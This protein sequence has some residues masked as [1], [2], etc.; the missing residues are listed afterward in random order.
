MHARRYAIVF[1]SDEALAGRG[2]R[3][4]ALYDSLA[5]RG[6][7]YQ[8]RHG[9][10]RPGWFEKSSSE[11]L[12]SLESLLPKPYDFYGAYSEE[13]SGWRLGEGVPATPKHEAHK[14]NELIEGELT[15]GW[16]AS[17]DAVAEE[18]RAA[19]EGVA[20]FDTSYFGKLLLDG[21]KADAAMQWMCAADL[22]NK[23]EGSVTYTPLC[24]ANG[25]V[26]ADLT[27]TKLGENKWYL[28]TGGATQ[29]HD[30]RWMLE[31]M[32]AGGFGGSGGGHGDGDRGVKL[33]N[34]SDDITL[35]SVQGPKSHE[36]LRPLV[37]DGGIDDLDA[38]GFSTARTVMFAGVPGVRCL[39]LT[40]MGELGFELHLP[41]HAAAAAYETVRAA[42]AE[43]EARSGLPVRDGG[44]M[45]IDS[46]SAEK[47]YR[48]WH[49]DLGAGDTPL[50]AG[51]GFTT[52]PKLKAESQPDFL[53]AAALRA[54]RANG[55][56]RRLVTL[57][58]DEPGGAGGAAPPLHG[59]ETLM[60][61]GQTLG[62]VRSTAYGHTLGRSI[63]T[64]Y[65]DCPEGVPKITPK[66]LREG[67]WHVCSKLQEP[68]PATLH[69]K[70]PFDPDGKRMKGDYG[71]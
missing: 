14:Y 34:M 35:L 32:E 66:W 71:A 33:H 64:G 69:L 39:R 40:F 55:L 56:Q 50:E 27:V 7:V 3:K 43:L 67:V 21:P 59:G 15:F 22:A 2:A 51:I 68:M 54:Q 37:A 4:S 23:P 48:H 24:N 28:V 70:A 63:V 25:G 13:G 1:P 17:F 46:L 11:A 20:F 57:V 42:G 41:S 29:S 62:I 44:Y 8:A 9:Y 65:V 26:E 30:V 6:C 60:R 18:C 5:K 58:L 61:D 49:A 36:L 19:R 38:F 53:G 52:L 45:A 10:E 31:A 47:S 12:G 16:P